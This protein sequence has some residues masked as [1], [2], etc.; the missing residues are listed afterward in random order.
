MVAQL[1]FAETIPDR[2][3]E[4]KL[5]P[6]QVL[7]SVARH[8]PRILQRVAEINQAEARLLG[9]EGAFDLVFKA[10]S[11]HWAEGFYDGQNVEASASRYLNAQGGAQVYGGYKLS[12]GDFPIYE[13]KR[14]TN[15]A[16]QLNLGVLYSLLRDREID[17]RRF[18]ITDAGLAV[19]GARFDLLLTRLGIAQK[20][21]VAYWRWV[22]LGQKREVY[23]ELLSI[24]EKRN[25]GLA[26]EVEQGARARIVLTESLQNITQRKALLAKSD[27]DVAMAANELALFYRDNEGQPLFVSDANMP[28][29][30]PQPGPPDKNYELQN[31]NRLYSV[32]PELRKLRNSITRAMRRI[33][34]NQ[35]ALLPR[36]DLN[37]GVYQPLG[38]VAEGGISRDDT[39]V[40][41]GLQFSVPL[42][43]RK[44]RGKLAENR[45]KLNALRQ[46]E[47]LMEDRIQVEV[48][49]ILVDLKTAEDL[50]RLAQNEVD[51]ARALREAELRRFIKGASDYFLVNIRENTAAEAEIRYFLAGLQREIA[52]VNF[53]A[54]TANLDSLGISDALLDG[55]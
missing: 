8:Y 1:A 14:F 38:N 13:D 7:D 15:T 9:A 28:D 33:E 30:L 48:R 40:I 5:S 19:Q 16:G 43:R 20:A 47:R 34:L 37:L 53:D 54:A 2:V 12:D 21:M 39:D 4:G 6:E 52:Q 23:R 27:R 36:L 45:A 44:A 51:Q 50:L 24:A 49:N 29:Y 18:G 25:D 46:Q 22:A 55:N 42:E 11:F 3:T 35:N 17:P 26:K 10:N 41:V 32:R 31:L